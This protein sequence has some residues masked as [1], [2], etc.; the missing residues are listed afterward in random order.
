MH[1]IESLTAESVLDTAQDGRKLRTGVEFTGA[2][3]PVRKVDTGSHTFQ[4]GAEAKHFID[5]AKLGGLA[6]YL[7]SNPDMVI[8]PPEP[9]DDF[10]KVFAGGVIDFFGWVTEVKRGVKNDR[11]SVTE[12]GDMGCLQ[13]SLLTGPYFF[14]LAG[15]KV[16]KVGGMGGEPDTESVGHL[17]NEPSTAFTHIHSPDELYLHTVEPKGGNALDT[18][19]SRFSFGAVGNASGAEK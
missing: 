8:L 3:V 2:G 6:G 14:H 4:L 17:D 11:L 9:V 13:D 15:V 10:R 12:V 19:D 16:D 18:S 7:R 1:I 5:V